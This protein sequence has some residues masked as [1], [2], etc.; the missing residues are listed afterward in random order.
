MKQTDAGLVSH[1]LSL[2]L[3]RNLKVVTHSFFLV[4]ILFYAKVVFA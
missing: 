1:S 4:L 3:Q 2:S